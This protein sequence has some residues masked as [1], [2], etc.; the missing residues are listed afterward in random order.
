MKKIFSIAL[1]AALMV[2]C[3]NFDIE[4]EGV[5]PDGGATTGDAIEFYAE[6]ST[7]TTYF[8][9][10]GLGVN[11]EEGDEVPIIARGYNAEGSEI[12]SRGYYTAS[13]TGAKTSFTSTN[14]LKWSTKFTNNETTLGSV[15]TD[16]FAIHCG[17][18]RT[19]STTIYKGVTVYSSPEQSQAVAND[20]S[21]IGNY[22]VLASDMVTR[23]VGNTAP[24]CFNFINC[25]SVVELTLKGDASKEITDITLSSENASLAFNTALLAFEDFTS[26]DNTTEEPNNLYDAGDSSKKVSLSLTEPAALSAKG[27]KFYL[28]LMPG[29]HKA[30]DITLTAT[31]TDGTTAT[32]KMGAI[33]FEKNKVYR[34]EV[35]L[36]NF[37]Q[38][39]ITPAAEVM[40]SGNDAS[41][42]FGTVNF[43]NGSMFINSRTKI[44]GH[45]VDL[46]TYNIPEQFLYSETDTWQTMSMMHSLYP[47]LDV[48]VKTSGMVY[49]LVD[50]KD[51]D[52][53]T[54]LTAAGWVAETPRYSAD[55]TDEQKTNFSS[56][57][58]DDTFPIFYVSAL[59]TLKDISYFTI[60]S[61]KFEAN[62]TFNIATLM[63]DSSPAFRGARLVAKS[64][65]WPVA[66]AEIQKTSALSDGALHTFEEGATI[67]EGHAAV[68]A[69]KNKDNEEKSIPAGYVGMDFFTVK[70][71][72]STTHN[73]RTVTAK[74]TKS[75][76]LYQIFPKNA[77]LLA[78]IKPTGKNEYDG[79]R[80]VD[81]FH[82]GSVTANPFY[83]SAKWVEAGEEI[84]TLDYT[85]YIEEAGTENDKWVN[86]SKFNYYNTGIFMGKL[87]VKEVTE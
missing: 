51:K 71:G 57:A 73:C 41:K 34:P 16:F 70:R 12:R 49:L 66:E 13:S 87:T 84:T 47:D 7:K 45:G 21:H 9:G 10:K 23:E 2:S 82:L 56:G 36:N 29:S 33:T 85:S 62:E 31:A 30:G 3:N 38:P 58:W 18:K 14:A 74:V 52:A 25:M 79:W 35:P 76:M 68:I 50:G 26:T 69:T 60:Y 83:I 4:N 19:S 75:G 24:I 77:Q 78:D 72:S 86:A 32:V 44:N 54:N 39:S 59:E 67:A 64:I 55:A 11:W 17:Y 22:T 5:T 81:Y 65:Q 43:E 1:F 42:M 28:V 61:K 6:E 80:A 53:N 37:V 20:Y 8:V 15:N 40:V 27:T 63:N 48:T 46:A